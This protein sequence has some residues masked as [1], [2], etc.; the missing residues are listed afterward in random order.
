MTI[1]LHPKFIKHFRARIAR[2]R[3]LLKRYEERV[4]MFLEN[5]NH[6][7]LRNHKL[8]GYASVFYSFSITGDI[9]VVYEIVDGTILFYDIG[10]HNQVY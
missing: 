5:K 6:P 1:N 8:E 7:L 10:T 3:T 4:A 9:R 2:N